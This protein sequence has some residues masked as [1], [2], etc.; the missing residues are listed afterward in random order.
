[1]LLNGAVET[2]YTVSNFRVTAAISTIEQ[3]QLFQPRHIPLDGELLTENFCLYHPVKYQH[4]FISN[5]FYTRIFE[6]L[7]LMMPFYIYGLVLILL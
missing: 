7:V 5:N 4:V 2:F 6:G 3:N 1:M